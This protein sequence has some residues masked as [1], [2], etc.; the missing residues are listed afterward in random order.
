MSDLQPSPESVAALVAQFDADLSA[1]KSARDAQS[2]RD[3]YLGRKN[4]IV[5]SWMQLIAGAPAD[6]KKSIGRFANEL[7]Q[8]IEARWTQ[9]SEAAPEARPAG[10]VD[11]T[12]PGRMPRLGHRHPLTVVRDQLEEIFTRMGFATVEGPEAEDEWHCFDALNMPAE[13]PARDMQDTLYLATPIRGDGEG[14]RRTLLRTHTSSMQIRYMQA[15]TPPIRIVVPGRVYRRD[16]LDLTHSPAFGQ[17]EGLAV[18]EGLSLADLK[19]TLLAFARQMFSP[20]TRIRFRP[21]FFPYTEPSAE[22]DLSCWQCDGAGC[23]M[24]KKTGW[25]ELGGCG[26]VHPAVFE[27]VGYDPE[28]YTGFAWGIGIERVAILRYQVEDIRLFYENDLRFLEQFP[29]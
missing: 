14:D 22:I 8:A 13:H 11:V 26:M 12:L 5:A 28:K 15:H 27:A 17:I 6:Q 9:Y 24:C 18:G 1:A 20:T 16:D 21:S 29:Y 7:K 23:A 25:I 3:R 4:S 10:A 19:G 2:L